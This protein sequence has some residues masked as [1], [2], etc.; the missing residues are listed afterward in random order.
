M[1]NKVKIFLIIT[2][3]SSFIFL[4]LQYYVS[5]D[6]IIFTNKSRSNYSINLYKDFN[7]LPF[8]KNDTGDIIIYIDNVEEFNKKRKKRFWER[9]ISNNNE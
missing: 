5:D 6:N 1:I 9:L 8:L 7:N 2:L 3:F 4:S